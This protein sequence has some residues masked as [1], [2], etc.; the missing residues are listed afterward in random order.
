MGDGDLPRYSLAN[1]MA[2]ELKE[3]GRRLVEAGDY[4]LAVAKYTEAM[5]AF[6]RSGF[7]QGLGVCLT[8]RSIVCGKLGWWPES[9]CD[10]RS[11]TR[12]YP[13][14]GK[15]WFRA[16]VALE[17]LGKQRAAGTSYYKA[18]EVDESLYAVATPALERCR[19]ASIAARRQGQLTLPEQPAKEEQT[20]APSGEATFD[21]DGLVIGLGPGRCGLHSLA[22]LIESSPRAAAGCLSSGS[23]ARLLLWSPSESRGAVALR[24]LEDMR[25]TLR[26][27]ALDV[28]ADIHYAWLPYARDLL[29]LV[30]G[31]RVVVMRRDE[32]AVT[33]SWF[34]W[35]EAGSSRIVPGRFVPVH[36]HAKNHWQAHDQT[37]FDF[38]E[39]DLTLPGVESRLDKRGAIEAYVADYYRE[40]A[41]LQRDFPDRVKIY[42][43]PDLFESLDQRKDLYGYLGLAGTDPPAFSIALNAQRYLYSD[44]LGTLDDFIPGDFA[45]DEPPVDKDDST[46]DDDDDYYSDDSDDDDRRRRLPALPATADATSSEGRTVVVVPEGA[47]PG[48]KIRVA[49]R[50]TAREVRVPDDKRPGD[51][52][53]LPGATDV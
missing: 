48:D 31:L 10:A 33:E 29:R 52:I 22:A 27:E 24:R 7:S 5:D 44:S 3:D 45:L 26:R 15:A 37:I 20:A 6:G 2:E 41:E 1:F 12:C 30:P 53:A 11:A 8:N 35:T 43:C 38:D 18:I 32:A 4:E 14:F 21:G 34:H 36:I 49:T 17:A 42:D 47:R 9:Y 25:R 46:V 13:K 16:G 19:S 40:C 50:G 39:W 23:D 51:A 28:V